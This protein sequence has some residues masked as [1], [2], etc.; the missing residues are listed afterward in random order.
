MGINEIIP[1]LILT[2]FLITVFNLKVNY[3]LRRME[4]S[5]LY[6]LRF[7]IDDTVDFF[8]YV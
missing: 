5:N 4:Q 1:Y 6:Y 7:S 2:T 8:S 3:I